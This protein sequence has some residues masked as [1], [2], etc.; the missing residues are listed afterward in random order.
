[1]SNGM[2]KNYITGETI[3][4]RTED[5]NRNY[6]QDPKGNKSAIPRYYRDKIFRSKQKNIQK[7][8]I[9]RQKAKKEARE[10][11][12]FITAYPHYDGNEIEFERYLYRKKRGRIIKHQKSIKSRN[13]I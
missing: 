3:K 9:M 1:M 2:G 5:L 8:I 6:G 7:T 4:W 11:K 12:E 13:K 10:Y